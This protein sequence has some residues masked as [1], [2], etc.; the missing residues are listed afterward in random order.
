MSIH[1]GNRL[2]FLG[3]VFPAVLLLVERNQFSVDSLSER[4]GLFVQSSRFRIVSSYQPFW[5]SP[6]FI[7]TFES[8]FRI[9][10]VDFCFLMNLWRKRKEKGRKS[11]MWSSSQSNFPNL[12]WLLLCAWV[13]HCFAGGRSVK[14]LAST[15]ADQS[16]K[17]KKKSKKEIFSVF[18]FLIQRI[19]FH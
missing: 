2:I 11:H 8:R 9:A 1:G 15:N 3:T 12:M 17:K 18:F 7:L 19:F 10:I 16:S 14:I 13:E 4:K 5:I 6:I